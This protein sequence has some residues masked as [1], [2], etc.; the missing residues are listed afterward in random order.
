MS[1][2]RKLRGLLAEVDESVTHG[3]RRIGELQD[4]IKKLERAAAGVVDG[5]NNA[6]DSQ[7]ESSLTD[8][9]RKCQ[10]AAVALQMLKNVIKNINDVL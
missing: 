9:Q 8:A 7:I 1:A 6:V 4:D 3:I 5:T 10:E 2:V